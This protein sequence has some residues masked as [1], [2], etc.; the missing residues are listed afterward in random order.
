MKN[1]IKKHILRTAL[2]SM[3]MLVA[4]SIS[5]YAQLVKVPAPVANEA[6]EIMT[7]SF[8][9]N[10]SSNGGDQSITTYSIQVATDDSFIN[11]VSGYEDKPMPGSNFSYLVDGL[12]R[13]T[14]FYYRMKA[15]E[16]GG[17]SSVWS[18]SIE[19]ST[20]K[21]VN[22]VKTFVARQPETS[23]L[24]AIDDKDRVQESAVYVDGLGRPIQNVVRWGSND[25]N[26]DMVTPIEYDDYGRQSKQYL[27]YEATYNYGSYRIDAVTDQN[28]FYDNRFG[29]TSGDFAFAEAVYD[30]SP[31][32]RV[33][34]QGAPGETWKAS[35]NHTVDLEFRP[36]TV[37][38]DVR[39]LSFDGST[40]QH[41]SDYVAG[42]LWVTIAKD[43]N[44]GDDEGVSLEFT[45][46]LGQ[47]VLKRQKSAVN[48][49]Y[50]TYYI[51]DDF[52]NIK[53]ILQPAGEAEIISSSNDW[54]RLNQDSFRSNW[55]FCY[56][57]DARQRMIAK[58]VPGADWQYMIYDNRDRVVLTQTGNQRKR[59]LISGDQNRDTYE[60]TSYLIE[61]NGSL[62]MGPGF[63]FSASS[64]NEYTAT[65]DENN[66]RGEWIYT[67]YDELNRPV[68]TGFYHSDK[69]FNELANDVALVSDFT[70]SYTGSANYFGYDN[71]GFP[72]STSDDDVLTVTYYDTYDFATDLNSIKPVSYLNQPKGQLTGTLVRILGESTFLRTVS[73][74]DNRYRNNKMISDNHK[75]GSD[76]TENEYYNEISS[77]VSKRTS[78]HTSTDYTGTLKVTETQNYDHLGRLLTQYHQIGDNSADEILLVSNLYND[79]G[80]LNNKQLHSVNDGVSFK[81]SIDYQYN[82][83]G[84]LSKIN[85]ISSMNSGSSD[86]FGMSLHYESAGYYDGNIGK[87]EWITLGGGT[88]NQGH[89]EYDYS[90]DLLNRLKK[91]TYSSSS[92]N[93]HFTVGGNDSGNIN[94]DPNGNILS[95]NRYHNGTQVDILSYIYSEG[96]KLSEVS[97]AGNSTLFTDKNPAND[98]PDYTYDVD[99]NMTSDYNKDISQINYNHLNLPEKFILQNGSVSYLYD[100][101][102]NR[103]QKTYFSGTGTTV[104]DYVGGKQYKDGDLDFFHHSNGRV[105][106]T[107]G[108]F[109]YQYNLTDHL[110]NVRVTINESGGVEQRNGYYPFGLTFNDN[111]PSVKND[112]LYNQGIGDKTFK[113]ERQNELDLDFTKFRSYDYTLG[114]FI[115]ID[116]L[117]DAAG[118]ENHNSYHYSFNNPIMYNDPYGDCPDPDDPDC[119]PGFW[120][121]QIATGLWLLNENGKMWNKTLFQKEDATTLENIDMSIT[122]TELMIAPYIIMKEGARVSKNSGKLPKAKSV[123]PPMKPGLI[124]NAVK[125]IFDQ[126]FRGLG[127]FKTPNIHIFKQDVSK[128]FTNKVIIVDENLMSN[129]GQKL[130]N[131]GFKVWEPIRGMGIADKAIAQVATENGAIV[132]TKNIKDFKRLKQIFPDLMTIKVPPSLKRAEDADEIVRRMMNLDNAVKSNPDKIPAGGH[133]SLGDL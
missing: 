99:G 79:L 64:T 19:V 109:E 53:F 63:E 55:M 122:M 86:K 133:V 69:S 41:G 105:L 45:N 80:E 29:G 66:I 16:L 31:L 35:G 83:R 87:V 100:A 89:Q 32:N 101:N 102:G 96:N 126:P 114:R 30:N 93:N 26:N 7:T 49:Y 59:E 34:K 3:I 14:T 51:Y 61:E 20:L 112:Y 74:Y 40:I 57:Y 62:T 25:G 18:N 121:K 76:I 50:S 118:Q 77:L 82:I 98:A 115:Q 43:E 48:S 47:V 117:A 46:T 120:E 11:L 8:T 23:S 75:N 88:L 10:W 90:Y 85:D 78:T 111:V 92:L 119:E 131:Q 73:F 27:P 127:N 130:A 67:K 91:A 39:K 58:K 116:P 28:A 113:T 65:F 107:N 44:E 1:N 54:T 24:A 110:G 33:V 128:F 9:A 15:T 6:T 68:V 97:D 123:K 94:Y 38:D 2:F 72:L 12:T 5:S 103:L 124:S 132:L 36:N 13:E 52:S 81:Q 56:E 70:E 108:N 42:E 4:F 106:E 21:D 71:T 95:L 22:Y 37:A 125:N 129:L 84:W 60:N 17:A 104:S